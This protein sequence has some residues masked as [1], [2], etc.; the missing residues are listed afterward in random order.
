[1]LQVHLICLGKLKESFWREAEAEYLK[2][3]SPYAKIQIHE[4]RE[5]S[6]SEKDQP[7]IIKK[8]EAEKILSAL[9]KINAPIIAL[10]ETGKQFSSS[11]FATELNKQS[12]EGKICFIIGG[13]L[14]LDAQILALAKLKL[15]LSPMTF[16]HQ[17]ARVFLWEQIYRSFMISGGRKYHY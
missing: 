13:P 11:N 2:R 8:K 12:D 15:S 10:T 7:E 3:L 16:T 5:E 17:M 6:F 4:L 14:G 1:M 9:E